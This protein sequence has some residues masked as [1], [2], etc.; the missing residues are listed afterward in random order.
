MKSFFKKSREDQVICHL[1]GR[2]RR[3]SRWGEY[4]DEFSKHGNVLVDISSYAASAATFIASGPNASHGES[5]FY[6]IHL[7]SKLGWCLGQHARRG[8]DLR[9]DFRLEKNQGRER[10]NE[11][12]VASKA[13]ADKVV[14]PSLIF[15]TWWN[16][17]LWLTRGWSQRMG[18]RGRGVQNTTR[19]DSFTCLE[20]QRARTLP[21]Y[22]P[23]KEHH[24]TW[25]LTPSWTKSCPDQ[26]YRKRNR[27]YPKQT[28]TITIIQKTSSWQINSILKVE[29]LEST[30][31]RMLLE[32][33][34]TPGPLKMPSPN[35]R[36][37]NQQ[38]QSNVGGTESKHVT[39]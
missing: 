26:K 21:A 6:L 16:K 31:E 27:R 5:S 10:E 28:R 34:T 35:L 17:I 11:A 7:K 36:P 23:G 37:T 3:I 2:R 39:L 1:C 9:V 19:F 25:M 8:S 33:L 12:L 4:K 30:D 20:V 24:Q 38:H 29:H 18:I 22:L 32:H 14:N 13:C 15:S